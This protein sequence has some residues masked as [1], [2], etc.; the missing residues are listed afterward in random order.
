MQALERRLH[1]SSDVGKTTDIKDYVQNQDFL[2]PVQKKKEIKNKK[3][4]VSHSYILTK[5]SSSR[6]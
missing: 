3:L 6:F 4:K 5:C 2:K 1:I